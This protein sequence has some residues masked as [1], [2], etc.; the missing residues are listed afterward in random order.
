MNTSSLLPAT[1]VAGTVALAA[2]P[3]HAQ[4]L[5]PTGYVLF[6]FV[7]TADTSYVTSDF[8]LRMSG[9]GGKGL[10]LFVDN[11][12]QNSIITDITLT[13]STPLK[14]DRCSYYCLGSTVNGTSSWSSSS[15]YTYGNG[16]PFIQ[17]GSYSLTQFNFTAP[18]YY[19]SEFV[20]DVNNG[21]TTF[22]ITTQNLTTGQSSTFT[23]ISGVNPTPAPEPFTI[24][25]SGLAAGFG[26]VIY[27]QKKK[28]SQQT[29]KEAA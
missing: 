12:S 20:P 13:G 27:R 21:V 24:L 7:N 2:V 16:S 4:T 10:T 1:L 28:R 3:A 19:L 14:Q 29:Q 23:N 22:A 26:G 17:S 9:Y 15:G 18:N 8:Q 25:G 11:N 5:A 6:D